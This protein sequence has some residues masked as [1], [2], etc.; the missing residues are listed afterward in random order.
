MGDVRASTGCGWGSRNGCPSCLQELAERMV[1][2]RTFALGAIGGAG[3]SV[4]LVRAGRAVAW[5]GSA[6]EEVSQSGIRNRTGTEEG[7]HASWVRLTA[8]RAPYDLRHACV[9]TWLNA[10]VPATWVA[11]WAGHSVEVLMRVCAKCI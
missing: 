4:Q 7:A 5:T 1:N 2:G 9:S 8:R 11:E 6:T 10:G 3:V